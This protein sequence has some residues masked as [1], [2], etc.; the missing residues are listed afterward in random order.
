MILSN[1]N[2]R[3]GFKKI[4]RPHQEF[5]NRERHKLLAFITGGLLSKKKKAVEY[6]NPRDDCQNAGSQVRV[7]ALKVDMGMF[8]EKKN[9][10]V[11]L[12]TALGIM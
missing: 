2:L 11:H 12:N 8:N 1:Q 5:H 3:S 9:S 10:T 4:L 7:A 6:G